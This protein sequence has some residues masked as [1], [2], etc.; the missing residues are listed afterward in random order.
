LLVQ[1]KPIKTAAAKSYCSIIRYIILSVV[2]IT[3]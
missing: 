2:G 3:K 1:K